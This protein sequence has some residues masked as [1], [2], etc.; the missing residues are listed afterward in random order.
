MREETITLKSLDNRFMIEQEKE[1]ELFTL[2]IYED[3]RSV[4]STAYQDKKSHREL[5]NTLA[6]Y[7]KAF[8]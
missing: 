1:G 8:G 6:N 5:A 7:I 2:T 4:F 3:G